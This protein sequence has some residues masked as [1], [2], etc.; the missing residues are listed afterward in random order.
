M[1]QQEHTFGGVLE[2][3]EV[4]DRFAFMFEDC[5]F[6]IHEGMGI[7][8]SMKELGEEIGAPAKQRLEVHLP[9]C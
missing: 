7:T 6:E 8:Y 5:S 9:P 4:W 2:E 3:E 1:W